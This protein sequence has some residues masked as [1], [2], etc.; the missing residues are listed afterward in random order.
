MPGDQ[1]EGNRESGDRGVVCAQ[2]L[3]KQGGRKSR[4][5]RQRSCAGPGGFLCFTRRGTVEPFN[6]K[7]QGQGRRSVHG[8]C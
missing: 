5:A 2:P 4:G 1:L 7:V 8:D 3:Q 6:L